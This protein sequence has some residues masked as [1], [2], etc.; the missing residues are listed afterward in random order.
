MHVYIRRRERSFNNLRN[1]EIEFKF[2]PQILSTNPNETCRSTLKVSS[3][4]VEHHRNPGLLNFVNF[5]TP[6]LSHTHSLSVRCS[7]HNTARCHSTHQVNR[8]EDAQLMYAKTFTLPSYVSVS[9][10]SP[11]IQLA[12]RKNNRNDTGKGS[13]AR[14]LEAM[15]LLAYSIWCANFATIKHASYQGIS[16]RLCCRL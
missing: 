4:I 14:A 16:L 2:V 10:S 7:Y 13:V 15:R 5:L 12:P 1:S 3:I 8:R 9:F 11:Q 6:S